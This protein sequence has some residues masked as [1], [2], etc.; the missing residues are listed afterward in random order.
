MQIA[1]T[2][3]EYRKS[4]LDGSLSRA[5][6]WT[7]QCVTM[8]LAMAAVL[9][10][11]L[12]TM[13]APLPDRTSW[14]EI[15]YIAISRNYSIHGLQFNR[16]EISWPAEPPRVT[17]M[18]LPLVPYLAAI[19]Y[20]LFGFSAYTLRIITAISFLLM[21]WYTFLLA[22]REYDPVVGVLAGVASLLMPLYHPFGMSLFSEPLMIACSVLSIYHWA[23]WADF[24]RR[25]DFLMAMIGFSLA[26]ALK[27]EPLYLL[28]PLGWVV[29]RKHRFEVRKYG[30]FLPYGS[31][32]PDLAIRLVRLRLLSD[33]QLD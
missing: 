19:L 11:R 12:A 21:S 29:L 8:L 23:E 28:I 1:K 22:R 6:S 26:V 18:E 5:P 13:A 7:V 9:L 17:A 4:L 30:P 24:G 10:I 16:P 25:R 27:L 15:D 20:R 32:G 3:G 14:K 2:L 31:R 33:V